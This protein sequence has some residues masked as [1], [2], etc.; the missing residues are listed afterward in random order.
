VRRRPLFY[1][2]IVLAAAIAM[3]TVGVGITFSLAVFLRPL[4]EEFGWSRTLISGIALVNWLIF[5]VCAFVWGTLSDRVGTGRVVAAGA[6]L[7]GVAMLLSSRVAAAWQLY[8]AFGVLGAAGSSAFYV[9]LS[10]TAT[11]WFA[12]RR[13]LA[14]GLVSAGM[15]LGIM[16]TTAARCHSTPW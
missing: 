1:G 16:V 6:G 8:L 15:G 11:R 9:P 14:L 3:V 10:A 12:A 2:W 5:G 13:G 4:E 7:L